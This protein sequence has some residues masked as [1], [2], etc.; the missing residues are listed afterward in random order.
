M[1]AENKIETEV[2]INAAY[3]HAPRKEILIALNVAFA[4]ADAPGV[5]A[6]VT[7]D[8]VWDL[9]GDRQVVGI[10]AMTETL[11]AMSEFVATAVE[12]DTIITE[13][14]NAMVEG[15]LT[16]PDG[17][18]YRFCDSYSFA[19]ASEGAKI[20]RLVSYVLEITD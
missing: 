18:L 2:V 16:F 14:T 20:N 15:T 10:A 12:I 3:E 8:I 7:D 5:L 11:A 17:K 19:D 4:K 1:Q 6:H 9:I 13:D